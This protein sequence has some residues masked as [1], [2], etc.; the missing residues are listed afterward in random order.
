VTELAQ[1]AAN[2]AAKSQ[3]QK[4]LGKIFGK[5]GLP[6]GWEISRRRLEWGA[7]PAAIW[8]WQCAGSRRI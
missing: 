8:K 6:G 1:T 2:N 4:Y 5:K 7:T 3:G